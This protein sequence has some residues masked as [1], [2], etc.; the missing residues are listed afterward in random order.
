V[1]ET[2]GRFV[3][4]V[5]SIRLVPLV[6][7]RG[8][9]FRAT[10]MML[11]VATTAL[12]ALGCANV[13]ILLLARAANRRHEI[14]VRAAIGATRR[15]LVGQLLVESLV[16]AILGGTLGVILTWRG[17]PAIV[18]WLPHNYLPVDVTIAINSSIL[19]YTTVAAM[20][21]GLLFGLLPALQLSKSGLQQFMQANML[22]AATSV[23]RKRTHH[24][25]IATQ[26]ALS[27][28]LL[29]GA[30]TALTAFRALTR[31]TL[32]FEP[33]R[34][35]VATLPLAEGGYSAWEDRKVF[36]DRIRERVSS[37]PGVENASLSFAFVC[38]AG[39]ATPPLMPMLLA[40][41]PPTSGIQPATVHRVAADFFSTLRI[42]LRA[43]RI[44]SE[45][46]HARAANVAVVAQQAARQLGPDRIRLASGFACRS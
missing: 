31:T 34:V 24:L 37:I 2:P 6:A 44:W 21:V 22:L 40:S 4:D 32:N 16:L 33:D 25:I 11:L 20:L 41:R 17:V 43:G 10:F 18:E 23:G 7:E 36:F 14:A 8:A 39:P 29:A 15:R 19:A 27:V 26:V 35:L 42:P 5:Q 3:Q 45:A 1:S 28:L 46:D 38:C 30:G 12:L 9:A 13:S